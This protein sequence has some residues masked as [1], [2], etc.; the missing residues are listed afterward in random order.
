MPTKPADSEID[1]DLDL[2]SGISVL[3]F[4]AAA[5]LIGIFAARQGFMVDC[6]T[7]NAAVWAYDAAERMLEERKKR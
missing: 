4:F 6:G 3:D 5:A 7:E 1:D 2:L